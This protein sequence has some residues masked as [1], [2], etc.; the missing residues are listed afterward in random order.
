MGATTKPAN[1]TPSVPSGTEAEKTT[2]V[3]AMIQE[4]RASFMISMKS[5]LVA[6]LNYRFEVEVTENQLSQ[7]R[8]ALM[9]FEQ[10]PIPNSLCNIVLKNGNNGYDWLYNE[11]NQIIR[12]ILYPAHIELGVNSGKHRDGIDTTDLNALSK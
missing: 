10:S 11:V 9:D 8:T 7:I 2:R 4:Q 6:Y 5:E 3:K 12:T 1:S